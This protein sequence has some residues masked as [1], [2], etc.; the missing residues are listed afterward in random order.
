MR[1]PYYG[2][3]S[4]IY[5][6]CVVAAVTK[7]YPSKKI[8]VV[9]DVT[10]RIGQNFT[11]KDKIPTEL[12]SGVVYE[13]TCSKCSDSY[14][15]KTCRHLKTRIKEHLSDQKKILSPP[16]PSEKKLNEKV[17]AKGLILK[18]NHPMT[19]RSQTRIN[20]HLTNQSKL[21]PKPSSLPA[22]PIK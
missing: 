17:I 21:L 20:Q 1:I 10:A 22:N 5:A 14:I 3:S 15:G 6:K 16:K 18:H 8:R 12:K 9:Y 2:Q 7:Q 13:A 4:Y 11:T 19:T